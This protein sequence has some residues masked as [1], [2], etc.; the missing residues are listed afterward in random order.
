MCRAC[1]RNGK[2]RIVYKI[3]VG[4]PEEKR[5]LD[6]SEWIILKVDIGEIEWSGTNWSY[7]NQ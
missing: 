3:L 6:I 7:L 5:P 2:K 4:K 1:S